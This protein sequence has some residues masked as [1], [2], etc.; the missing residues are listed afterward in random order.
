MDGHIVLE[1]G[2]LADCLRVL[3][4]T[5]ASDTDG[6]NA[7]G[8]GQWW[9]PLILPLRRRFLQYNPAVLARRRIAFHYD[10]S[11][12]L[13][14]L[15]LDRDR[16]YSCAYFN[17]PG[18][19]LETAQ[20]NKQEL[21]RRKLLLRPGMR[22]LDIGSGWGGLAL[23]FARNVEGLSVTGIT[24]SEEQRR[25]AE[26]RARAEG[27]AH[28]VSF[29]LRDYRSEQGSYD[30][31]VSV[32]MFEHVG[33]NHYG[34]FFHKLRELLAPDG[35]AL[36]H[37][38]GRKDGPGLTNAWLRRYIFPGG[39]TP[40]LS[41]VLPAIEKQR[42]WVTDVEILRLHYAETL[43]HWRERFLA[44]RDRVRALYDERFCRMWELYLTAAEMNFRHLGLMVFQIQLSRDVLAVPLT[45]E[46][47]AQ[48]QGVPE[49][50]SGRL[51]A[52]GM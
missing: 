19:S 4:H 2:T 14:A 5:A 46:Y 28:R 21:I 37:A 6:G 12:E 18:D 43:R 11:E 26:A 48:P 33:V 32:G 36:L 29:H 39:Y 51:T 30:R 41:E 9:E 47:L 13:Y 15:F 31:I 3:A 17:T 35:I 38:I 25:I 22:V 1:K 34:R 44:H 27:L 42:L 20:A 8:A 45:R 49:L 24:L 23:S 50:S 40:A 10:L 7:G 16:N 52:R